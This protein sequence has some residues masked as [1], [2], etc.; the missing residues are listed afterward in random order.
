MDSNVP[1][2]LDPAWRERHGFA[3]IMNTNELLD[4]MPAQQRYETL[5]RLEK[6]GHFDRAL[7][8]AERNG[9]DPDMRPK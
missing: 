3:S 9:Y 1:I 6:S 7:D 4:A 2:Y 8:A 5:D